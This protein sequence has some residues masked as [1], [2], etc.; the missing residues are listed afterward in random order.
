MFNGCLFCRSRLPFNWKTP[1]GYSMAMIIFAEATY[2][3][4]F[5]GVLMVCLLVGCS[6]ITQTI[7]RDI[8]NDVAAFNVSKKQWNQNRMELNT[9]FNHFI[10]NYATAKQLSSCNA[11]I[12]CLSISCHLHHVRLVGAFNDIFTINFTCIFLW[13]LLTVCSALLAIQ[14]ELVE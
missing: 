2:Y 12:K 5:C 11:A 1:L 10:D 7:V 3:L 9:K 8:S 4:L 14:F 6:G 13:T